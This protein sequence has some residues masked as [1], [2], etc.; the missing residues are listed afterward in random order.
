MGFDQKSGLNKNFKSL[1][2]QKELKQCSKHILTRIDPNQI[3][4]RVI[5]FRMEMVNAN[6]TNYVDTELYVF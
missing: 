3:F 5:L 6:K 2:R 1:R 4:F